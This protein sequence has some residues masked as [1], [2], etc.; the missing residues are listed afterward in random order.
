MKE[1]LTIRIKPLEKMLSGFSDTFKAVQR[2]RKVTPQT[3]AYFTSIEAARNFLTPER[4]AL[5]RVIRKS[6]PGSVYE[7]AK[8]SGRNLKTVQTDLKILEK[9]GL[10]HFRKVRR[11]AHRKAKVPEAPY[12]E[13]ALKIAI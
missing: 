12:R 8:M 1:T 7:L 3:G 9:H 4:L 6:R 5:L 10:V 2:G 11:A 13:I